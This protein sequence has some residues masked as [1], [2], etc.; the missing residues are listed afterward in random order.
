AVERKS[1]SDFILSIMDQRLFQQVAKMKLEYAKP[2]ILIEGDVFRT[3]SKMKPAAIAGAMSYLTAIAGVNLV[4][5]A[6]PRET[7]MMLATMARHLQEGLGY[8]IPMRV[9]KPKSSA[10]MSQ[11]LVESLASIGPKNAKVLLKHFGSALDVFNASVQDLCAIKG[12]G[13]ETA[14][15]IY[16]ALR[17]RVDG[18]NN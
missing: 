1:A 7:A 12:L 2:M 15:R 9:G 16:T 13:T 18:E 3:R 5:I 10:L 6:D 4:T 11:Y 17:H 14:E 8:E